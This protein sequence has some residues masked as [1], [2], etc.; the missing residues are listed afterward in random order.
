[1]GQVNAGMLSG[2]SHTLGGG[3]WA[4]GEVTAHRSRICLPLVLRAVHSF[5]GIWKERR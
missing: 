4:G 3:F 2:G 1:M 5:A